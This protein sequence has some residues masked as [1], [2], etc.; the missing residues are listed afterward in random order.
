[1]KKRAKFVLMLAVVML[2]PVVSLLGQTHKDSLM[3]KQMEKSEKEYA[4]RTANE[5]KQLALT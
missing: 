4:A 3:L 5:K 1:M 2:M